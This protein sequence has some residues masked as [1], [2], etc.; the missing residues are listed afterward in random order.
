MMTASAI[1]SNGH[2]VE[3]PPQAP[4]PQS[5]REAMWLRVIENSFRWARRITLLLIASYMLHQHLTEIL[6]FI[7]K[8]IDKLT[9]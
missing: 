3:S 8:V 1:A 6:E 7:L 4:P 5:A 2:A 9:A